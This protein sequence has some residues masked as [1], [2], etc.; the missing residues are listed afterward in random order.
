MQRDAKA[1]DSLWPGLRRTSVL[2]PELPW[3]R[4]EEQEDE[5]ERTDDR[6]ARTDRR[7][8]TSRDFARE[9]QEARETMELCDWLEQID[10]ERAADHVD[11]ALIGF[12]DRLTGLPP[13]GRARISL[14]RWPDCRCCV[15]R[16]RKTR[17]RAKARIERTITGV[18]SS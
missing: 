9:R 17:A 5:H 3:K 13:E 15:R 6:P 11:E 10:A 16:F 14:R 4:D 8:C 1:I 2:I 12:N 18:M 7:S